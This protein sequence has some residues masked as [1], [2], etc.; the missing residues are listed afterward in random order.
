MELRRIVHTPA[1]RKAIFTDL[2]KTPPMIYELWQ[3]LLL[4]LGE[5]HLRLASRNG[6]PRPLVTASGPRIAHPNA[7]PIRSGDI[8]RPVIRSKSGLAL[9]LQSLLDGPVQP[10]P[11]PVARVQ[12][13][14]KAITSQAVAQVGHVQKEAVERLESTPTGHLVIEEAKGFLADIYGWY[15]AEWAC[16]RVSAAISD[17]SVIPLIIDSEPAIPPPSS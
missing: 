11:H 6:V 1:R 8:F 4:H 13:A 16:R 9:T 12:Q 3:E 15:G 17:Y 7:I 10:L 14:T 2:S 5:I